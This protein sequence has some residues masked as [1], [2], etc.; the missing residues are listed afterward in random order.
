MSGCLN[1]EAE[2]QVCDS[3]CHHSD[4]ESFYVFSIKF[5]FSYYFLCC[6]L[7]FL[8]IPALKNSPRSLSEMKGEKLKM[9]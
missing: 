6:L 1:R 8:L 9:R 7:P 5:L 4:F 2:V 3:F